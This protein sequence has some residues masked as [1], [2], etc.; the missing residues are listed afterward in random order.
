MLDYVEHLL[1]PER[2]ASVGLF[3]SKAVTGLLTKFRQ[4]S[5][6]RTGN[7]DNVAFILLLS[8]MLLDEMFVRGERNISSEISA[9]VPVIV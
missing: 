6:P 2:I 8:T 4:H 1:S 5:L 7:R 9:P 3:D